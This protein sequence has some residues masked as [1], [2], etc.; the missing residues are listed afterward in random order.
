[1]MVTVAPDLLEN[2]NVDSP[3][4][5]SIEAYLESRIEVL[6][7]KNDNME[8]SDRDTMLLRAEIKVM[9]ELKNIR[10]RKEMQVTRNKK[11]T[12]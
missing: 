4:W 12:Y 3:E 8:L 6:R 10:V 2:V 9:Q 7:K 5:K 1:M 11:V